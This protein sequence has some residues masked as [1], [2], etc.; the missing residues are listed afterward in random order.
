MHFER[1]DSTLSRSAEVTTGAKEV[2]GRLSGGFWPGRSS[3]VRVRG[4]MEGEWVGFRSSAFPSTNQ[5]SV[6]V[7]WKTENPAA[8]PA[9]SFFRSAAWPCTDSIALPSPIMNISGVLT[10]P[11]TSLIW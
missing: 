4:P 11:S 5:A 8:P 10:R 3:T 2:F 1:S 7:V 9:L 6:T